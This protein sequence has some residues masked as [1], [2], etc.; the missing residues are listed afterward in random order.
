MGYATGAAKARSSLMAGAKWSGAVEYNAR[1]LLGVRSARGEKD[2]LELE[3][4]KN[5]HGPR[6]EIVYLRLDRG[7]QMLTEIERDPE[8]VENRAA[9]AVDDRKR[10]KVLAAAAQ[11]AATIAEK[12]G[13]PTRKFAPNV[14]ARAPGVSGGEAEVGLSKLGKAVVIVRGPRKA[15]YI[16]LDG[17]M[18]PAEVLAA[19]PER[20]R[21][22]VQAARPPHVEGQQV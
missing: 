11:V 6:D 7:C 5:K 12:P 18:V 20:D 19:I 13:E 2:V 21:A 3:V 22:L 4:S 10:T 9:A 16:Y 8:E 1:V 17:S 14:R 15:Q